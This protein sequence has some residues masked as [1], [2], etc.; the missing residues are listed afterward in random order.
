MSDFDLKQRQLEHILKYGDKE[1]LLSAIRLLS[2]ALY[3]EGRLEGRS[4]GV[5]V[6]YTLWSKE[7]SNN[8]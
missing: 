7:G 2:V 8:D 5:D 6:G 1:D 4:K 3:R